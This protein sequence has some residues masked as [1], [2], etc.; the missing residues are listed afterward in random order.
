MIRLLTDI[1]TPLLPPGRPHRISHFGENAEIRQKA[2]IP[3]HNQAKQSNGSFIIFKYP[4]LW[5]IP[6]PYPICYTTCGVA[7]SSPAIVHT[8]RTF[9]NYITA[10]IAYRIF[11]IL[12]TKVSICN[13]GTGNIAPHR[14]NRNQSTSCS[15][16]SRSSLVFLHG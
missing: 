5:F 13:G 16:A 3:K 8:S 2:A 9:I 1:D 11:T 6:T 4:I 10:I 7:N 14:D 15:S 12:I